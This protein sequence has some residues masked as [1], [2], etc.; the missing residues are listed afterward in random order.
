MP[1]LSGHAMHLQASSQVCKRIHVMLMVKNMC[2]TSSGPLRPIISAIM[3][4]LPFPSGFPHMLGQS[5]IPGCFSETLKG[6]FSHEP[7]LT[8]SLENTGAECIDRG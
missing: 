7:G 6:A 1:A 5:D 2:N 8:I 4:V 3:V